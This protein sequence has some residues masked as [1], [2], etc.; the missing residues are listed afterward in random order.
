MI[1]RCLSISQGICPYA[2]HRCPRVRR[3]FGCCSENWLV[4]FE[5]QEWNIWANSL[6]RFQSFA[7]PEC[8]YSH[9]LH[10][11]QTRTCQSNP[12]TCAKVMNFLSTNSQMD[13]RTNELRVNRS[14]TS[15]A[16][17]YLVILSLVL[18]REIELRSCY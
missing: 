1:R 13:A 15:Q 10:V 17:C 6:F 11:V 3:I 18:V 9:Q 16:R 7:D 5:F 2:M 14:P 8:E 12:K 4:N